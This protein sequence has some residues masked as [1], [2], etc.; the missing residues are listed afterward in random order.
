MTLTFF[1]NSC[2]FSVQQ[3]C[4][5]ISR[6][7]IQIHCCWWC[8][9]S[10]ISRGPRIHTGQRGKEISVVVRCLGHLTGDTTKFVQFHPQILPRTPQRTESREGVVSYT[11][12]PTTK[13]LH[14][15]FGSLDSKIPHFILKRHYLC[16]YKYI[17]AFSGI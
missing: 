7:R 8:L 6:I 10:L 11:S 9:S 4:I 15:T 5:Y 3:V 12:S 2:N 13:P 16:I 1:F 14:E 17:C